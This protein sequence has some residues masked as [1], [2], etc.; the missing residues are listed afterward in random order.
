MKQYVPLKPKKRAIKVCE[1]GN[2]SNSYVCNLQ[3]YTGRQD[4]GVTEHRLGSSDHS[5][6]AKSP[7][8]R[9]YMSLLSPLG[10]KGLNKVFENNYNC[11]MGIDVYA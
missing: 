9:G 6:M 8:E 1:C 2:S 5:I 3:V 4:G 7:K 11:L 10:G